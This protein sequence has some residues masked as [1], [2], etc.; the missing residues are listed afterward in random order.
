[1]GQIYVAYRPDDSAAS[2]GR[3]AD[4]L[5][6][7]FGP[8]AVLKDVD[9][10]QV[11]GGIPAA[12][13]RCSAVVVL[14]GPRWLT[15]VL[16]NRGDQT[17]AEIQAALTQG[18]P[19]IPVLV[20]G[21]SLPDPRLLPAMAAISQRGYVVVGGEATFDRDLAALADLLR[22]FSPPGGYRPLRQAHAR[23]SPAL[24]GEAGAQARRAAL[25]RRALL[26]ALVIATIIA[27]CGGGSLLLGRHFTQAAVF[28]LPR[29]AQLLDIANPPGTDDIWAVGG[30]YETC[31]LL[32]YTGRA[33]SRFNCPLSAE[34]DSVSF[35]NS[36]EGWAVGGD[37][38]GCRL[39]HFRAGS[40]TPA[41]CPPSTT[42]D[43]NPVVRMDSQGNGW[44]SGGK[45][46]LRYVNG[47]W[48]VYS[49]PQ[50]GDSF[51]LLDLAVSGG[52]DTWAW[53]GSFDKAVDGTWTEVQTPD[54]SPDFENASMDFSRTNDTG[55]AVGYDGLNHT[56]AVIVEYHDGVW[57][58]YPQ[59]P[60]V[61]P[62]SLV[63]VG[64]F[65]DVWAAG[66]E[67]SKN[68]TISGNA[69]LILRYD[70]HNWN[71]LGDPGNGQILGITDVPDGDAW[72]VSRDFDG[73]ALLWYHNGYW[74]VFTTTN[75]N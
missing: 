21:A 14:I 45:R 47:S 38:E 1:M 31:V 43:D 40:W 4:R 3:V 30:D 33:W 28:S 32:H 65:G 73:A 74:R 70:G 72:A 75:T 24:P 7:V 23:R 34:L 67:E 11:E 44:I 20:H 27:A 42:F 37:Y 5:R 6:A 60:S 17:Y 15:G 25:G 26:G 16:A 50:P 58:P 29:G 46:M 57:E 62:L 22:R 66:G 8:Q 63:R 9:G 36:G 48:T 12:A 64:L 56:R 39:L 19:V 69:G 35:V 18:V 71:S 61:G 13:G 41:T 55:W 68:V 2:S 51:G 54:I 59:Q 49:G 53:T 10:A 52:G